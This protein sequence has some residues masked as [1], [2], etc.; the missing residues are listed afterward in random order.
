MPDEVLQ[1]DLARPKKRRR[2]RYWLFGTLAFVIVAAIAAAVADV[3][4]RASAAF[5][6]RYV[7]RITFSVDSGPAATPAV[8]GVGPLDVR[9]GYTA[10]PSIVTRLQ[11]RGFTI[12]TQASVSDRFNRVAD[13]G[14]FPPYDEPTQAGLT[15]LGRGGTLISTSRFPADVYKSFDEIPAPVREV[16]LFLENRELLDDRNPYRNPAIEWDRLAAAVVNLAG[17]RV[18][19]SS[20][21]FGASTLATQLE[22]VRHSPGGVTRSPGDKVRQMSSA[23]LRAYQQGPLTTEARRRILLDYLNALPVGAMSGYGEV[24]GIRDGVRVWFGLDPDSA[25]A[26]LREAVEG[27]TPV[28]AEAARALRA[29]MAILIAQRRPSYYLQSDS[30]R[31]NLLRLTDSHLRLV[32]PHNVVPTALASAALSEKIDLKREAPRAV[33]TPFVERKAINAV[34]SALAEL[35][36]APSLYQLDRYDLTAQTTIDSTAQRAATRLLRRL[37][38][39]EFVHANALDADRLLG[40]RDPSRVSYALVL[41]ERTATGNA[42]RVQVDNLDR[43]FD[44]NSGA[45]LELGSTAKLRTLVSYLDIVAKTYAQL[46]DSLAPDTV[47]ARSANDPITR[48]ARDVL[49][50]EP[51]L[52]LSEFL[53]AAMERRYV[54]NPSE[55]F[56]TGGGVHR[57]ANFD[58]VHDRQAPTVQEGF[59]HSINLVFI[60][61]MRDVVAWHEHRLNGWSADVLEDQEHPGRRALLMRYADAEGRAAIDRAFRRHHNI[62]AD[63]SLALLARANA[64]PLRYGRL[65]RALQPTIAD[66][67]LGTLLRRRFPDATVSAAQLQAIGRAVPATLNLA[68]RAYVTGTDPLELWVASR[69]RESP[70]SALADLQ[71]AGDTARMEAFAWLYRRTAAVRQAQDRAIR[72][73]LERDAFQPILASWRRV[74]YPYGDIVPSLGTA[75]GSSGDRPGALAELVGIIV[76]GGERRPPVRI[77]QVVLGADSPFEVTLRRKVAPIDAVLRPEVA[78][79]VRAALSDVV[80][81]GTAAVLKTAVPDGQLALGGKTGT[82]DNVVRTVGR[83]GRQVSSRTVSRTA[84]FA[85][86]LGDRFFGVATAYVDGPEAD[87]YAFTSG[88]PVRSVGLLLPELRPMLGSPEPAGHLPE[89]PPPIP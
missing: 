43:P 80:A 27:R 77:E 28:R 40:Q 49:E 71:V 4:S 20:G 7:E 5:L 18:L 86:F 82:G 73:T 84:T 51:W 21:R 81:N 76:N 16:L 54:A 38:D 9:L 78:A 66:E 31:A 37:A 35:V 48:W 14:L 88:L 61:L 8:P 42:L 44:L 39:R 83:D 11:E 68:D 55:P 3:P 52:T 58:R 23:T 17:A 53:T 70:S 10:I 45:R 79:A 85:F 89:Q 87:Q 41:Y 19:G 57:F 50:N 69:L 25:D 6:S 56:F 62:S 32:A 65:L 2:R 13:L 64:T 29:V 36:G 72:I 26:W 46:T 60:R 33:P 30:G 12:A 1:A 24:I 63:S 74:G 59:R 34:R 22:K 75:I 67:Q 47:S 15:L